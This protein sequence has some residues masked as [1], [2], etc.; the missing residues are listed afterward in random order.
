MVEVIV[1][2]ISEPATVVHEEPTEHVIT[3]PVIIHPT[4]AQQ[5]TPT[6]QPC[7]HDVLFPIGIIVALMF[8]WVVGRHS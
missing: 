3:T 4:A 1:P 2:H 5:S 6:Q 8:G 7:S